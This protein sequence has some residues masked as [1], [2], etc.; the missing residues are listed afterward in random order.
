MNA[1][2]L[3]DGG[4]GRIAK[5][6]FKN[7][8]G[9]CEVSVNACPCKRKK[10]SASKKGKFCGIQYWKTKNYKPL[11]PWNKGKHL[12]T[13]YKHKI[14]ISLKGKSFKL[15]PEKESERRKK[16]SES[17][18]KNPKC[19]G[20]REGSGRGKKVWY[21]SQIAGEVYLRSTYE[22]EYVKWLDT[23]G[24]KWKP[25]LIKF[26]YEYKGKI[27]YYY[28]DFYLIDKDEYVEVKGFR[29]DKDLE[30]W[31]N[32]P[33]KLTVLMREDLRALGCNVI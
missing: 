14:S 17:M 30:K 12:S 3:C 24:I 18:K 2:K 32:F 7:G 27:H 4:C 23:N 8:R 11:V 16:I 5:F 26:P 20:L 28:P 15:S 13:E 9:C 21:D 22:L 25:N 6:F 19:G 33:Y 1:N 10:D 31:K 29:T